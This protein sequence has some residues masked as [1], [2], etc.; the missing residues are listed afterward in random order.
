[1]PITSEDQRI[2]LSPMSAFTYS[3]ARKTSGD[4]PG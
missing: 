2:G 4:V 3:E 1:M